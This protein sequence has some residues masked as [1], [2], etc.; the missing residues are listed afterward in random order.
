[1]ESLL[2]GT[3]SADTE[4]DQWLCFA[5]QRG[6]RRLFARMFVEAA[7]L[8]CMTDY[9]PVQ[10]AAFE[11]KSRYAYSLRARLLGWFQVEDTV[12]TRGTNY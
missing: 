6:N 11:L 1:M 7:I 9:V 12:Q 5:L 10:P 3:D 4:L 8:P 2:S